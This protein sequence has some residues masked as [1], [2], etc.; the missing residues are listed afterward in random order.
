M[1]ET[2]QLTKSGVAYDLTISPHKL[3]MEYDENNK[4]IYTFSSQLY[5]NKFIDKLKDNRE[6]VNHSLSKRFGFNIENNLLCDIKLYTTIEKR[7]FLLDNTKERF[8]CLNII[9]LDGNNLITKN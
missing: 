5:K 7:G 9:K 6:K 4:M 2:I 1:N 8:E 3:E